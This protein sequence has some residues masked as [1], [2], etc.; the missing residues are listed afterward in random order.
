MCLNCKGGYG[1]LHLVDGESGR[2]NMRRF[3]KCLIG[4]LLVFLFPTA[5]LGGDLENRLS[6][7][8]KENA[9]GY[10]KPLVDAIGTDLNGGLYHSGKIP[11]IGFYALLEVELVCV[12]FG[13]G[14]RTFIAKTEEGFTPEQQVVV[15][16][17]VG[18]GK[19]VT[20]EGDHGTSF[21]FPGGLELN[22]FALVVPQVRIGSVLGTEALVRYFGFDTNDSD[23]GR[24]SYF[25]LGLRHNISD[26]LPPLPV[27]LAAGVFWQRLKLGKSEDGKDL[28][29]STA[30]SIGVAASK[31]IGRRMIFVEPYAGFSVESFSMDVSYTSDQEDVDIDFG[32]TTTGRLTVGLAARLG[33]VSAYADY[34]WA[35][36]N[37]FS[38]GIGLGF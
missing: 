23:I 5:I 16:T 1:T 6:V 13:D 30:R 31:R 8:G 35:R 34:N 18:S 12:R 11:P 10:I 29:S 3:G 25:G 20:V 2:C 21:S 17:V 28:L 37:S 19:S 36:Q 22:S 15:P 27:D 24:F 7:Y 33:F 38:L 14:D 26:Y 32:T 9:T 4:V